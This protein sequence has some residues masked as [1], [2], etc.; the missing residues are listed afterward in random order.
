MQVERRGGEDICTRG[1]RNDSDA[2]A[3]NM[4]VDA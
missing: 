3:Y 4:S 1:R 2:D